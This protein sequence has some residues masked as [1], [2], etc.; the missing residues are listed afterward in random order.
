[1]RIKSSPK[2]HQYFGG[3]SAVASPLTLS[4]RARLQRRRIA[5]DGLTT[6]D[7][8]A[9]NVLWISLDFNARGFV[10]A[11]L[12]FSGIVRIVRLV[13]NAIG[14]SARLPVHYDR[15]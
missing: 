10:S 14:V 7:Q 4:N 11:K 5:G 6:P 12:V 1:M 13:L 2:S 3:V 15:I 9:Q 8:S